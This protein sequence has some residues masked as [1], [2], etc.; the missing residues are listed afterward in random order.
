MPK[1]FGTDGVRG[2]VN[3]ELTHELAM[4]LG[5][6]AADVLRS[7]QSAPTVLVGRDTRLSGDMLEAALVAGL[8]AAGAKVILLGIAPTPAVAFCTKHS[9]ADAGAV[10]SASHN[11]Y[12]DNGIKFFGTDGC[13]LPDAIEDMIEKKVRDWN[14]IPRADGRCIGS[15]QRDNE[16]IERYIVHLVRTVSCSL[17]GMRIVIDGANGAAFALAPRVLSL[18]GVEVLPVHC[19]P[20][21]MNINAGCGSLS[22]ESMRNTVQQHQAIA[23]I[24]FDGDADRVIMS[25]EHGN[26]VDG[27]RIMAMCAV[28]LKDQGRLRN[29]VLVATIMSNLGLE[30]AMQRH[31]IRLERTNVGDRYV[32]ERMR[33]LQAT[34]GGEK[35]GH[36]IFADHATTGDGLLTA[37]QVLTLMQ[38]TGK[39]LSELARIME[40]FPQKLKNV[41]VRDKH[42]WARDPRAQQI[43]QRALDKLGE[44][45]QVSIRASGTEPVVRIMLQAKSAESIEQVML[46]LEEQ[47]LQI[48][49]EPEE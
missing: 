35:S 7:G 48:C 9:H 21:G 42:A 49:G 39:P 38:R 25:D 16:L 43:E 15:V 18:L 41:P 23:G 32:A 1:L 2:I 12:Q 11:P 5:M 26:E 36:I 17:E 46:E 29:N 19:S 40:E 37:L 34:L 13:K 28:H 31:R 44:P 24:S 6:A 8:C 22:T 33:E 45:A 27:D 20:D 3:R 10:I 47:V 4:Q 30:H 14:K